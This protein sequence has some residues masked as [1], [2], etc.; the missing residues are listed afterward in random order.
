MSKYDYPKESN[1][2]RG[3][4]PVPNSDTRK[5]AVEAAKGDSRVTKI[6]RSFY[7]NADIDKGI[8]VEPRAWWMDA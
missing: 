8:K 6:I 2:G 3:P 1:S 7:R 5:R 4:L